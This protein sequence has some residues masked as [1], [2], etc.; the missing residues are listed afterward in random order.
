MHFKRLLNFTSDKLQTLPLMVL[1]ITDG[2]NSRCVTCDIWKNPRRNMSMTLVDELVEAAKK[3][4]TS[5]VLLSGGESM[6][7]PQ[8]DA[9]ANR[10]R[11]IGVRVMLL[12][13]GL[14]IKAHA[15][16]IADSVD[17]LIVSLDGGTAET[18][19]A[20]RGV[21]G[22]GLILG[23]IRIVKG[24]RPDIVIT[25][26]T[27]V[28]RANFLEIPQ[29]I[30]VASDNDVDSISF[31]AVDTVNPY[32]FGDRFQSDESIPMIA[33]MGIAAPSEHGPNA[34]S[35]TAEDCDELESILTRVET[36]FAELFANN[37]I[38]ESPTKLR[39]ILLD[40]FRSTHDPETK[41]DAPAC[42]APHFSTVIEVDGTLRPC[43]FLPA[44]G[45]L[46]PNHGTLPQAINLESAQTLRQAYRTGQR[47][48]CE[49]CV[50]PLF[51]RPRQLLTM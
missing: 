36:D 49:R 20:I 38:A 14:Y 24:L 46:R 13:N 17:D 4:Q 22:F 43:Y 5:W 50:C 31:L 30:E 10:F 27:T 45:K 8:W 16:R 2:C 15:D 34:S 6:Q 26:R 42:N 47:Q 48:E 37:T 19:E 29:I 25:T 32:A 40:Y 33:N 7:H 11:E 18:Y 44:Y 12:T 51:K 39:R 9:I 3:L 23:G 1:Y 21:D 35:L 28:Q 41:F